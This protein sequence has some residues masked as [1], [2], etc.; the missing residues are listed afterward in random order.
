[1]THVEVSRITV[2]SQRQR[3]KSKLLWKSYY[4]VGTA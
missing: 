2:S 1:M 3:E 4:T